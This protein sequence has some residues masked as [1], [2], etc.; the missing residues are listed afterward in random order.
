MCWDQLSHRGMWIQGY[1]KVT[2]V[3]SFPYMPM[4]GV[5]LEGSRLVKLVAWFNSKLMR[6]FARVGF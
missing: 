3:S 1:E 5:R 2:T 4:R 6:C